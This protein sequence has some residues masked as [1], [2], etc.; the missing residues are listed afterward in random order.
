VAARRQ[1]PAKDDGKETPFALKMFLMSMS[2][3]TKKVDDNTALVRGAEVTLWIRLLLLPLSDAVAEADISEKEVY[4]E[5]GCFPNF[6]WTW[7][8]PLTKNGLFVSLSCCCVVDPT[9]ER[10]LC[11]KA[12]EPETAT[13][14]RSV[15]NDD[16][17]M[18]DSAG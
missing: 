8:P 5:I 18:M 2:V 7:A 9:N 10:P 13:R 3:K 16:V 14:A 11:A 17:F 4:R 1:H 15:E 6:L 12:S